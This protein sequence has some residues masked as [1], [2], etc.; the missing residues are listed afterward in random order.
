MYLR[1]M[2]IN[3]KE[4][5]IIVKAMKHF[6]KIL[7][8]TKTR[9][10]TDNKNITCDPTKLS[11]RVQKMKHKIADFNYEMI[12]VSGVSNKGA[13][14]ISRIFKIVESRKKEEKE[15]GRI[16]GRLYSLREMEGWQK[17]YMKDVDEGKEKVVKV[18]DREIKVDEEKKM[19][20]PNE[21]LEEFL[22]KMHVELGHPGTQ[23]FYDKVRQYYTGEKLRQKV[24]SVCTHV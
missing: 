8:G 7:W 12:H 24:K 11:S 13:D 9:I 23:K 1:N 17:K 20:I 2:N 5:L 22:T 4:F 18:K 19:I 21:K 6:R 16:M 14:Y 15:G 3:E 10:M